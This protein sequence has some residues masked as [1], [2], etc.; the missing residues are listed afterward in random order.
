LLNATE[1]FV[2]N[3]I[4]SRGRRSRLPIDDELSGA[5]LARRG[6]IQNRIGE[7]IAAMMRYVDKVVIVTG[8]SSGLGKVQAERFA[9]E[10]AIVAVVGTNA[11][12]TANTVSIIEEAG[13]RAKAYL[14]DVG[15]EPSVKQLFAAVV[16]DFGAVDVLINNAGVA[17]GDIYS[18]IN[19]SDETLQKSFEVNVYGPIYCARAFREASKGRPDPVIINLS[20]MASYLASG[21]YSVTKAAVNNLTLVL[22]T[23]L[24][25]DG[26]RVCGIAPGFMY[27]DKA[28][29]EV[30]GPYQQ[31]YAR[32]RLIQRDGRESDIADVALYLC[33]DQAGFLT[34]QTILVDG[35]YIANAPKMIGRL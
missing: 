4:G 35:G 30:P 2:R 20:S 7:G 5:L 18:V 28:V 22:A 9:A 17:Y 33:S 12:R 32:T 25:A 29:A 21:V 10:G 8:A 13:G 34:G 31:A 24:S 6:S 3:T 27:S 23:E 11:E 19:V 14:A 16:A 1:Y 15:S 26:I